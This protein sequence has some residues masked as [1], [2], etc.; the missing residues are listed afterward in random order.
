VKSVAV[1]LPAYEPR[2][3]GDRRD[4]WLTAHAIQFARQCTRA[5]VRARIFTIGVSGAPE[6]HAVGER[7]SVSTGHDLLAGIEAFA[8]TEIVIE[9][10][11]LAY[12]G[13]VAVPL[14][15]AAWARVHRVPTIL[16]AHPEYGRR[17][18]PPEPSIIEAILAA[19][20]TFAAVSAIL[21][22]ETAWARV[23]GHHMPALVLRL[24]L[25]DDWTPVE[26]AAIVPV[27]TA[28]S[29]FV[30]LDDAAAGPVTHLFEQLRRDGLAYR[31]AALFAT[32]KEQARLRDAM[33][34]SGAQERVQMIAVDDFAELSEAFSDASLVIVPESRRS[35]NAMRWARC[36]ATHGRRAVV[37][38]ANGLAQP[39]ESVA[40]SSWTSIAH[41]VL[42]RFDAIAASAAA[43]EEDVEEPPVG[44]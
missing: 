30:L 41:R 36:A 6:V 43:F 11:P 39:I 33:A 18:D 12:D 34:V 4:A 9:H 2:L 42:A 10:A 8:P 44:I 16:V 27:D 25:L 23:L 24:D 17:C 13:Q 22:H 7:W 31:C 14:S 3:H 5:N 15:V 29:A 35:D 40:T 21:C 19:H 26:P 32:A 20:P 38:H 1:I 37:L 28:A